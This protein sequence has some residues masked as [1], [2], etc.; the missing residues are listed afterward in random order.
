MKRISQVLAALLAAGVLCAV[1]FFAL[2]A[3]Q[4]VRNDRPI[5]LPRPRG[6][7][8]VGRVVLDWSH[9]ARSRRLMVFVWYP[10]RAGPPAAP[11]EYFPGRWGETASRGHFVIPARRMRAIEVAARSEAAVAPEAHPLLILLPAMGRAPADYT[12][13]AEE[14]A[15]HGFCVAGIAPTGSTRGIVFPDGQT[16]GSEIDPDQPNNRIEAPVMNAW[17]DDARFTV[18]RLPAEPRL[19]AAVD[20]DRAALVGH[21]FGGAVAMQLL[22]IDARFKAA[23]N[24]DGAPW[25]ENVGALDRPLLILL[26]SRAPSLLRS[27]DEDDT[28]PLRKICDGNRAGCALKQYDDAGNA[29]FTD[30]AILPSR[31]PIPARLMDRGSVGGQRF[32]REVA[33]RLLEFFERALVNRSST[34]VPR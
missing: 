6:P 22:K 2:V 30:E 25:R 23:A 14:L 1:I 9:P 29:D 13:L 34:T 20:L 12:T 8:P 16:A 7:H 19:A 18:E 27:F 4:Y 31:F 28:G 11:A 26:S 15:S 32:Q 21:S 3:I 24:L 33:D 10:A 17:L 5:A